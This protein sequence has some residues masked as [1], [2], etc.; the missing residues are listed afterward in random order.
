MK[1]FTVVWWEFAQSRLANEWL[2]SSNRAAIT[3][4]A[5]EI[6]RRLAVDPASCAES[7]HEGLH[8]FTVKPLTVQFTI[9]HGNHEVVIWTVRILGE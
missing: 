7:E 6:D 2:Q 1:P 4:A 3:Q 8:R 5:D 9:D